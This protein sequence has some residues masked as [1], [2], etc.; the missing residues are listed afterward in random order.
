MSSTAA[1]ELPAAPPS[2]SDQ[3]FAHFQRF[4]FDAAGIT[5]AD[6]KKL[7]VS[8][9]LGRRVQH[10]ELGSF[11][12]YF[13][14]LN[15]GESPAE[16]QT[17]IDLLTTNETYFFREPRH[18]EFLERHLAAQPVRQQPIRIWSAAGSTGEEAYSIAMLLE[19][20]FPGRSWEILASDI[21]SRVLDRARAG[22]YP[23]ER[24][25]HVPQAYLQRFCLKGTGR[26]RDTLLIERG[27][28]SKVSF[29]QINL[30]DR[31]PAIGTFD[32]V[33]LRN[34][35]IYFNTQT[36]REV[37]ARALSVLQPGGWLFIGH[38]ENLNG[39]CDAV[40]PAAPSI[41]RKL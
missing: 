18:F 31:L 28:R 17:A 12:Q 9:R 39:I 16:V 36:K 15:S 35:L 10:H 29:L 8:T 1:R 37:V 3:E 20:R 26:Q 11:A 23:M 38:S 41:Y 4:I 33:F 32:F 6:S 30:N 40:K 2:I 27:L 5:L 24:A 7:L 21:S 14:L 13:R 22:H 25:R 19:D 34:V